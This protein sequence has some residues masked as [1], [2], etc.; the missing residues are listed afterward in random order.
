[1]TEQE[2]LTVWE[3]TS[4]YPKEDDWAVMSP[5]FWEDAQKECRLIPLLEK[6]TEQMAARSGTYRNKE[7]HNIT[8]IYNKSVSYQ[9][10][11]RQKYQA[12]L[13]V[14]EIP[15]YM[16]VGSD[17]KAMMSI[18]EVLHDP[19]LREDDHAKALGYALD[20]LQQA[21]MKEEV[22]PYVVEL[23]EMAHTSTWNLEEQVMVES[24]LLEAYAIQKDMVSYQELLPRVTEM[25]QEME[26]TRPYYLL[27]MRVM[28]A[29]ARLE[30]CA[31]AD[32]TYARDFETL[33]NRFVLK[34]TM[35]ENFSFAMIPVLRAVREAISVDKLVVYGRCMAESAFN[36][37][38]KVQVYGFLVEELELKPQEYP[39]IHEGYQNALYAYY[40]QGLRRHKLVLQELLQTAELEKRYQGLGFIDAVTGVAN[41]Q[42]YEK[43]MAEIDADRQQMEQSL[44]VRVG[45]NGL[46]S[47]DDTYGR[48]AGDE[49][50][51]LAASCIKKTFGEA[52]EIF[53]A[54]GDGFAVLLHS[55]DWTEGSA[56]QTLRQAAA[57]PVTSFGTPLSVSVGCAS[58]AMHKGVNASQL[59]RIAETRLQEDKRRFYASKENDRRNS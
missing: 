17:T 30:G 2:L 31:M 43:R 44:W 59:M 20:I 22:V 11:W 49:L 18:C 5:L 14:M 24:R 39:D 38:D 36:L 48:F 12:H 35:P 10:E 3:D 51:Q 34:E 8:Q 32:D 6:I 50:L 23:R 37:S 16:A 53:R 46:K 7:V 1:M 15:F 13:K 25:M 57:A 52:G 9:P 28:G 47:V 4:F 42:M 56:E 58:Y 29:K 40:Y 27:Q 26:K 33:M 19:D 21:G 54:G 41:R 55:D 45:V